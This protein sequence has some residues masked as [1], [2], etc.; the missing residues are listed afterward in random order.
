MEVLRRAGE[1]EA[2]GHDVIHMEVG[3][4]DFPTPEPILRAGREAI[5]ATPMS[6]TPAL[7]IA[8][9]RSAIAAHYRDRFAVDVDPQRVI[10]T[11]G[12]SA[13]LLLTLGLVLDAG[14]EVLMG[15][16]SYPCNRHFV[17]FVDGVATLVPTDASTGYQVTADLL[18]RAWS[19]RTRAVITASPSNP[20]GTSITQDEI[21]RI[22]ALCADREAAFVADEIYQGLTYGHEPHTALSVSDD[23]YV[24]NSFSKYFQMTGWRL[25]WLVAPPGVTRDVEKLAQNLY[26][27]APTPSQHA[28]LAAFTPETTAILEQRRR[29]LHTRR[30]ALLAALP[31]IGFDVRVV[32]D[33]AFYI[34]CDVS[35]I[36]AD[37]FAFTQRVLE[38]AHVAITPGRDFGIAA[39]ERH[40]RIAYTQPVPRLLEA[41]DRIA[42]VLERT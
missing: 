29:E 41:V 38:Q 35:A 16:P 36:T 6:Y 19:D 18:Q 4:P 28:A 42:K 9:L 3:E 33:G 14:D 10:V 25:G 30:D 20:T 13:A 11:S 40:L 39:P 37:S 5:A 32:P 17:T 1:L 15:D 8:P 31:S 34:Y 27:C 23:A 26:I 22:A 7:G 21:G 2:A 24:I 12:S